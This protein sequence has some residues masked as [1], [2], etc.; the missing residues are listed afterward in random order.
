MKIS[1]K[2][3]LALVVAIGVLTGILDACAAKPAS[4]KITRSFDIAYGAKTVEDLC[5][6]CVTVVHGKVSK[7]GASTDVGDTV[8]TAVEVAVQEQFKGSDQTATTCLYWEEGGETD[9]QI[10]TPMSGALITAGQEAFF[11]IF[12]DGSRY[13]GFYVKD[14]KV[15]LEKF[16]EPDLFTSSDSNFKSISV[17]EFADIVRSGVK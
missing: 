14:G 6:E 10:A 15:T 11:F 3:T 7:I 9:T 4:S 1:G 16:M 5:S 12:E 17:E 2:R 13:P 8:H